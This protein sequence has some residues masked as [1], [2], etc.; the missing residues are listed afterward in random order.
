MAFTKKFRHLH[1]TVVG[2][3]AVFCAFQGL[4]AVIFHE[5]CHDTPE[6]ECTLKR[7]V[8]DTLTDYLSISG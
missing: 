2:Q 3:V 6:H 8:A 4:F 1:K 5:N 7:S